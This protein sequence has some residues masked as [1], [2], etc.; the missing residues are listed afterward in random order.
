[1]VSQPRQGSAQQKLSQYRTQYCS[2]ETVYASVIDYYMIII[3]KV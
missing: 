2:T 3:I 1:M